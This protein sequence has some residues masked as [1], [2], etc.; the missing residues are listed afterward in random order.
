MTEY[1]E[2]QIGN[3]ELSDDSQLLQNISCIQRWRPFQRDDLRGGKNMARTKIRCSASCLTNTGHL[4]R[5]ID[6]HIDFLCLEGNGSSANDESCHTEMI[7]LRID[8]A[9]KF[10]HVQMF[11]SY[12][13]TRC[14]DVSYQQL[15][16]YRV[17]IEF[18][19]K[20]KNA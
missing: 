1:D 8:N 15:P 4:D 11:N 20:C 17:G 2:E 14:F 7:M 3:F 18:R 9:K 6:V 5:S 16:T 12:L 19:L 13:I 10:S